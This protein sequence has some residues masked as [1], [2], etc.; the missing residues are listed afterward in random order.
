MT[1]NT[2]V[3][4]IFVDIILRKKRLIEPY[5][6]RHRSRSRDLAQIT[7]RLIV[8]RLPTI[9]FS[10]KWK[11]FVARRSFSP[12]VDT[13]QLHFTTMGSWKDV[14]WQELGIVLV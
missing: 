5:V 3:V 7:S 1:E 2:N 12:L 13:V 6:T 11:T 9:Y 4:Y 8:G 10:P 14:V